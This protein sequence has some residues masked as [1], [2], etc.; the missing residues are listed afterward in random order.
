MKPRIPL[1]IVIAVFAVSTSSPTHL[2]AQQPS[3]GQHEQH[4]PDAA[5]AEPATAAPAT[6]QARM[7]GMMEMM[8]QMKANDAKLD[9]LMMKVNATTGDA[10]LNA[11]GELLSALVDDR[12]ACEPMMQKMMSMMS[13]MGEP[14]GM[15]MPAPN[16]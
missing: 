8:E 4:H 16:K 12:R 11:M 9:A 10:K 6:P 5:A 15:E 14:G 2:H 3:A 13:K 1:L 7:A